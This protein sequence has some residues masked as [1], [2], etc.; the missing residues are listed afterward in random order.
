[1]V[2]RSAVL[3]VA[4]TRQL[5]AHFGRLKFFVGLEVSLEDSCIATKAV[6]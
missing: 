2:V 5:V 1:M 4:E 3:E 6:L